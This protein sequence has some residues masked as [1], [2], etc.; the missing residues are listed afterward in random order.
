MHAA[1]PFAPERA[2]RR[3]R[4]LIPRDAPR[5]P[6]IL[7]AL[8][9]AALLTSLLLAPVSVALAAVCHTVSKLSRWRPVWLLGPAAGGLVWALAV[10]PAAALAGFAAAP[11]AVT[12]L[13]SRVAAD[14]AT[15]DR[16]A[17]LPAVIGRGLAGEFPLALVLASALAAA[18]WWLDRL[19]TDEWDMAAPR[20]GLAGLCRRRLTTALVRSGRVATRDGACLG[21]DCATGRAVSLSWRETEGGVLV[22]GASWAAASA[23]SRQLVHAAIRRRTPV[24]VVDLAADSELPATLAAMCAA[25]GARLHVFGPAGPGHYD[26]LREH[27][28]G[29]AAD[30]V[31]GMLDQADVAE[32]SSLAA[33][34]CL[35]ALLTLMSAVPHEPAGS[36]LDD[37]VS[38]LR[39]GACRAAAERVPRFHPGRPALAESLR[40]AA[41]WLEADQA[42]GSLMAQQLTALRASA[43]GRWLAPAPQQPG[44]PPEGISVSEVM[45]ERAVALFS[46]S[47][48]RH[49]RVAAMVAS[50]VARDTAACCARL[51]RDGA[52]GDGLAWLSGCDAVD[53]GALGSLLDSG[54][55]AGADRGAPAGPGPGLVSVLTTT[56]PEAAGGLI[57]HVG[58][59]VVRG[60]ADQQLASGLAA[61]TG[62]RWAPASRAVAM[63]AEPATS[64]VGFSLG[65]A[66]PGSGE[67]GMTGAPPFGVIKAPRMPAESFCRLGEEEFALIVGRGDRVVERGRAVTSRVG[68]QPGQHGRSRRAR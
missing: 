67:T 57:H 63:A 43:L 3:A 15:A 35:A 48:A 17:Q 30:L 34:A 18:A 1:V 32:S 31:V 51:R 64:Q 9:I 5:R 60:L 33:R 45:R 40:A 38:L 53:P 4:Y 39:P 27:D 24:I 62:A 54:A 49:G 36:A 61:L 25:A 13:L 59:R 41:G 10:G 44:S 46:L 20:P 66:G 65:A 29:T 47:H 2:P 12:A 55:P 58:A 23:S 52:L 11:A 42:T 28:P 21:P 68:G 26:P 14:P 56:S 22:T 6:E 19:H 8:T 16:L 7:A 50:L 37:V